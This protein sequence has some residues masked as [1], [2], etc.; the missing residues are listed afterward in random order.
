MDVL[1]YI[2]VGIGSY[3]IGSV[4]PAL[5]ISNAVARKDIRNYGSGN[6]GTTNMVRT[7]GWQMGMGTFLL[8]IAKGVLCVL[9]GRYLAG[10]PGLLIAGIC[11]VVGHNWPVYYGFKGG[12]GIA[13]TMG[14]L[15][16]ITPA[17]T[18]ITL[19]AAVVIILV[20]RYVSVA[21]IVG[22]I[23]IAV[24]SCFLEQDIYIKIATV[25]LAALAVF[26]HR[27]NIKR[28][29]HGEENKLSFGSKKEK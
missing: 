6:A 3:L 10:S 14:V 11:V 22:T 15:F 13:T 1:L 16:I 25:V 9:A 27:A 28:L 2:G 5:I 19:A 26:G 21:S 24:V 18:G 20:T 12:K 8:D 7:F 29:I 23:S 17:I 4:S